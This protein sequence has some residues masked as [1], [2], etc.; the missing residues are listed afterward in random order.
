MRL[1]KGR[2]IAETDTAETLPAAVI[3][4]TVAKRYFKDQD[5]VGQ[6]IL[7]QRVTHSS[8]GIATGQPVGPEVAWQVVGVVADEKLWSLYPRSPS[9]YVSYK[10]SPTLQMSLAVRGAIHLTHLVKSIQ[11]A[12]WQ[13]NRNQAF[14][15]IRTLDQIKS[16]SLGESRLRTALLGALAGL[17]LL[18]AAIGIYGVISYSVAQRTHEM[19]IRAAL[20]ASSWDQLRLVLKSGMTL[21]ALG[22]GIGILGALGLTRLQASL[23]FGVSPRDPWTLTLDERPAGR[24]RDSRLLHPGATSNAN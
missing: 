6:R 17:A 16:D 21:T 11:A 3:N 22:M 23:L 7:I 12:V 9:L 10:Q 2:W 4:E 1:L 13:V 5:P 20:G 18:L 14:D 8:A 19:G 15:N 24:R